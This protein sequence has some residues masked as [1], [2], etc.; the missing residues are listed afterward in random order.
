MRLMCRLVKSE[1]RAMRTPHYQFE[2]NEVDNWQSTSCLY[3][4]PLALLYKLYLAFAKK[5]SCTS[6]GEAT[7][8]NYA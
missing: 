3:I 6:H 7:R 1:G 5:L 4:S 2:P 8:D